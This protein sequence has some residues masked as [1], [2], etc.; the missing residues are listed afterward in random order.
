[1]MPNPP[2][3]WQR[4]VGQ[5]RG[6]I[7][8]WKVVFLPKYPDLTDF[9]SKLPKDGILS[10]GLVDYFLAY[11][12]GKRVVSITDSPDYGQA[13]YET[14]LAIKHFELSYVIIDANKG[15]CLFP[16]IHENFHLIKSIEEKETYLVYEIPVS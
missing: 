8:I 16:Y 12:S 10:E 15:R 5:I 9:V 13:M 11:G 2:Y 14:E 4:I 6:I 1:M 7:P 3:R